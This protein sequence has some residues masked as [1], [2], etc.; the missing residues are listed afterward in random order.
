MLKILFI[1]LFVNYIPITGGANQENYNSINYKSLKHS[2]SNMRLGPGERFE[3]KWNFKKIGLPVK[4]IQKYELWYEVET[5]DGSRGWML[6]RLLSKKQTVIF[7]KNSSIYKQPSITSRL[8]A[9]IDINSI[10]NIKF[11]KKEWCKI[12]HENF[13][14]IGYVLKED[15]WGAIAN[16]SR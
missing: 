7:K 5:P 4:I 14:I 13:K 15:I 2:N 12:E 10:V 16:E 8:I 1:I 11:C 6:N 9:N 3:I